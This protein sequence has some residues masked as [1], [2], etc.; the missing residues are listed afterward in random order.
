MNVEYGEKILLLLESVHF[1]FILIENDLQRCRIR[2]KILDATSLISLL[3]GANA[4]L[5]A[6][7]G[8]KS[9]KKD[10]V[11][12][13]GSFQPGREVWSAR[14]MSS[15]SVYRSSLKMKTRGLAR[16]EESLVYT[17]C[18]RFTSISLPARDGSHVGSD[19]FKKPIGSSFSEPSGNPTRR[20]L[21]RLLRSCKSTTCF[22]SA[23]T[24]LS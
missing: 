8:E 4:L 19:L 24:R 13:V 2:R 18:A 11:A 5:F 9:G 23:A 10:S 16:S 17:R 6:V 22:S 14:R 12:S 1:R 7:T 20:R 3:I 21:L 15:L